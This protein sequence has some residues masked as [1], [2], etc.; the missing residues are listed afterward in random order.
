MTRGGGEGWRLIIKFHAVVS[1]GS[2]QPGAEVTIAA[3]GGDGEGI[4][5]GHEIRRRNTPAIG[6]V[7]STI[8]PDRKA[9]RIWLA[10]G[11]GIRERMTVDGHGGTPVIVG[12]RDT[13]FERVRRP[14]LAG[15]K[16]EV[17]GGG[18]VR[19]TILHRGETAGGTAANRESGGQPLGH[20]HV[21]GMPGVH[22]GAVQ[23][24]ERRAIPVANAPERGGT[25][26]I[27]RDGLG[28]KRGGIARRDHH[29]R[30]TIS[31][32]SSPL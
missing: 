20:A 9:P 5:A 32:A 17:N 11:A 16:V 25:A 6:G 1:P 19:T 15:S 10:G 30:A 13:D 27:R 22:D 26:G 24:F 7:V 12:V 29:V 8:G 3:D 31:T 4:R 21:R 28:V 23:E 18:T 2:T 14:G